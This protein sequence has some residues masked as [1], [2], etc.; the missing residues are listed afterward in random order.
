M[1]RMKILTTRMSEG[2]SK[3]GRNVIDLVCKSKLRSDHLLSG[4]EGRGVSKHAARS[5]FLWMLAFGLVIAWQHL[6]LLQKVVVS[7]RA[8]D[9]ILLVKR[10]D[11]VLFASPRDLSCMFF[12]WNDTTIGDHWGCQLNPCRTRPCFRLC[13]LIAWVLLPSARA[14]PCFRSAHLCGLICALMTGSRSRNYHQSAG[15]AHLSITDCSER[16]SCWWFSTRFYVRSVT[17]LTDLG[18]YAGWYRCNLSMWD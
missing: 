4:N 1:P 16:V 10:S 8:G 9:L 15:P 18:I 14:S 12:I 2:R 11:T 3:M 6:R 5:C 17:Q 13:L 7:M